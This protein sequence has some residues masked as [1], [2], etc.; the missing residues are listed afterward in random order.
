MFEIASKQST[1]IAGVAGI[2]ALS[3][4]SRYELPA[5]GDTRVAS[6]PTNWSEG[7]FAAGFRTVESDAG[8]RGDFATGMRST[9]LSLT[10]GDFATGLRTRRAAGRVRADFATG[11]R[12]DPTDTPSQDVQPARL[13][14]SRRLHTTVPVTEQAS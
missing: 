11:Q 5:H 4:S 12:T 13:G 10:V 7:D 3:P 8:A 14:R 1:P 6:R 2:D 9:M